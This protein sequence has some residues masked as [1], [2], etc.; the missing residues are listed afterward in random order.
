MV[1]G[2]LAP[3]P[4]EARP[5][6]NNSS[7][8]G[9]LA[10]FGRVLS[11]HHGPWGEH[12]TKLVKC[13]GQRR[14]LRP[15]NG[16]LS[17]EDTGA[18]LKAETTGERMHACSK[19]KPEVE[20]QQS[21]LRSVCSEISS[22]SSSTNSRPTPRSPAS[23]RPYCG[24][25]VIRR[26]SRLFLRGSC[27]ECLQHLRPMSTMLDGTL[28]ALFAIASRCTCRYMVRLPQRL[29]LRRRSSESTHNWQIVSGVRR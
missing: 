10:P 29:P 17:F 1:P 26:M 3:V 5:S 15:N 12:L 21:S 27:R 8:E 24:L 19:T 7:L 2:K 11:G 9:P 14:T 18:A 13:S 20:I 16:S 28:A 22:C 25:S 23:L 6:A 4:A